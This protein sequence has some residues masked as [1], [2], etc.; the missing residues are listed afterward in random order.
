MMRHGQ[1]E[2]FRGRVPNGVR[3]V[4][5]GGADIERESARVDARPTITR[6]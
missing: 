6:S 2:A 5:H 3:G 1:P 4:G